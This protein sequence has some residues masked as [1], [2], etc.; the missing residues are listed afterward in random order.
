[1]AE[2]TII[3][4]GFG[5]QGVVLAGNVLAQSA[6]I[7]GKNV[8]AMVSYGAEMRGGTAHCTITLSD[9]EIASP[10]V[11]EPEYLI[12]LN[13]PSLDKFEEKV[14]KGGLIAVNT[15]MAKRDTERKGLG[16]LKIPATDAAVKLG[17]IKAANI[18]MLG[19]FIRKTGILDL[20]NVI[21]NLHKFFPKSKQGLVELN[22]KA[23]KEGAE[24]V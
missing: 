4:S 24:L 17:N 2:H 19:A 1:M 11:E 10:I 8:T 5:G 18:V 15:S 16:I 22:R 12:A 14:L 3:I 9:R 13:Q 20:D 21:E 23:L 7:E 6:L